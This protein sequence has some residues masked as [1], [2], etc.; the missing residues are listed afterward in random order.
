M[1]IPTFRNDALESYLP[2]GNNNDKKQYGGLPTNQDHQVK[3]RDTR[4]SV[5]VH[6]SIVMEELLSDM[7]MDP[8]GVEE[9]IGDDSFSWAM[10]FHLSR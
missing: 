8:I 4:I 7:M 6:D 5:E 10:S 9:D 2:G 1:E 3:L